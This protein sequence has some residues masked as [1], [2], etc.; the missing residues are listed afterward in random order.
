LLLKVMFSF[1]SSKSDHQPSA[2]SIREANQ[3]MLALHVKI[4]DLEQRIREQAELLERREIEHEIQY[5]QLQQRKENEISFHR[6]DMEKLEQRCKQLEATLHER[7]VQMAYLLHRC[8]FL[9]EAAS[10]APLIEQLVH[11][12]KGSLAA[13]PPKVQTVKPTKAPNPQLHGKDLQQ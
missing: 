1:F 10:Y 4:N 11:C 7:D 6:K 8:S 12:L 2:D 3:H 13:P 5:K 9:D